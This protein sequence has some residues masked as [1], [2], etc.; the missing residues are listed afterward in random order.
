MKIGTAD[1]WF[2]YGFGHFY[3]GRK[4]IIIRIGNLHL[5]YT[6]K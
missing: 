6:I 4:Q 5:Y 2:F 1:S 3:G